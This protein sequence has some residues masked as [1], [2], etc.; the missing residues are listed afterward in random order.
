MNPVELETSDLPRPHIHRLTVPFNHSVVVKLTL[1]SWNS[2]VVG[3]TAGAGARMSSSTSR[4][5]WAL[6]ALLRRSK[7]CLANSLT[8]LLSPRFTPLS[9][10]VCLGNILS[11][12]LL[13]HVTLILVL[14]LADPAACAVVVLWCPCWSTTSVVVV[15]LVRVVGFGGGPSTCWLG[16]VGLWVVPESSLKYGQY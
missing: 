14:L 1:T 11:E 13:H 9:E 2:E 15:V 16:F 4:S 12:Q 10:V 6:R 7:Y 8:S 3:L 5:F